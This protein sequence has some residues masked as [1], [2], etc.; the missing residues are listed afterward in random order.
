[1]GCV[2]LLLAIVVAITHAGFISF[3]LYGFKLDLDAGR[4]VQGFFIISGYYMA[5]ILDGP[6]KND[7]LRFYAN[8]ALKIYPTYWLIAIPTLCVLL[9]NHPDWPAPSAFNGRDFDLYTL[10]ANTF[11]FG[12][13]LA[14]ATGIGSQ[15]LILAPAWS[16][17][18]ELMF[19]LMAPFLAR[20]SSFFLFVLAAVLFPFRGN[21]HVWV[22]QMPLFIIGML[23][24]RAKVIPDYKSRVDAWLG[25]L[26]YPV[27][28]LHYPLL[29]AY[30]DTPLFALA[31]TV[32]AAVAVN[33][34]VQP[35]EKLRNVIRVGTANPKGWSL[36]FRSGAARATGGRC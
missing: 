34:I 16:L 19:Y 20:R 27:Y 32:V 5:L 18:V 29:Q 8:R 12:Q 4:A 9:I 36:L 25:D 22:A 1:M 3:D 6:Y 33:L 26:S 21:L 14:M 17:G 7:V 2:R 31:L 15:Q 10:V 23:M 28:L 13:D 11:I 30:G 24:Y 35:V